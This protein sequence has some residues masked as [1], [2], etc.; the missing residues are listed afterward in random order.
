M[1]RFKQLAHWLKSVIA[2]AAGEPACRT[3]PS[4]DRFCATNCR[5]APPSRR[6]LRRLAQCFATVASLAITAY[7]AA[8]TTINFDSVNATAGTCVSA[9]S[10]L[11]GFGVTVSGVSPGS[12]VGIIDT[13]VSYGGQATTAPSLPNVLTQCNSN[14][15][16]SYTLNF[17]APLAS[18]SFT[19]PALIAGP[20]GIT[21]PQWSATAFNASGQQVASTGTV[22]MISSYSNLPAA[23][24][25]LNEAGITS[26]RFEMS[27]AGCSE[28]SVPIQ[29]MM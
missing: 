24:F 20:S 26:V 9:D 5:A 21:F 12:S 25:T 13:N 19:R 18:F 15:P 28:R 3:L 10:Y 29:D 14:Q 2:G 23:S 22:S 8:D 1:R 6:D 7:A 11:S 17:S 27:T 4:C 16:V